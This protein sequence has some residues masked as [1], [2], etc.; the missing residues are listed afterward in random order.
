MLKFKQFIPL[1]VT[2]LALPSIAFGAKTIKQILDNIIGPILD[3]LVYIIIG[4]GVLVFLWGLIKYITAG[5]D[6]EK[7]KEA[8]NTM[9][10]GI[11]AIFVMVAIW[12]LVSIL[13]TTFGTTED[14]P[15]VIPTL[16]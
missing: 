9:I 7:R 8:R 14:R 3:T 5:G 1:A 6:E 4:I 12:G 15:P 11:I 13:T 2:L 10:Y 16:P